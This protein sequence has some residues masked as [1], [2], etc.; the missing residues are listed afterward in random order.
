MEKIKRKINGKSTEFPVYTQEEADRWGIE[1]V[2][3]SEVQPGGMAL[4]DD[5]YVGACIS[6]KVYTKGNTEKAFIDICY[7]SVWENYDN[8]SYIE[9]RDCGVFS[10]STAKTWDELEAARTRA[11]LFV[12]A[13]VDMYTRYARIDWKRL[14]EIYRPDLKKPAKYAKML[15]HNP[16]VRKMIKVEI[17]KILEARGISEDYVIDLFNDAVTIAKKNRQPAPIIRVAENYSDMLQMKGDKTLLNDP[18]AGVPIVEGVYSE[19]EAETEKQL[20]NGKPAV[21]Q[22]IPKTVQESANVR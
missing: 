21:E 16:G 14:G 19:L 4:S 17:Q 2:H 9:R 20:T 13:Y 11:K 6:R 22:G 12:R 15:M 3:W 5:G 1:Y 18:F 8:L 7:G 10:R